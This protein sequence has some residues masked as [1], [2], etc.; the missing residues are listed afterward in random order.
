MITLNEEAKPESKAS[1]NTCAFI[2]QNYL[3]TQHVLYITIPRVE[4]KEGEKHTFTFTLENKNGQLLE[5]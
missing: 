4:L 5:A 1:T 3:G 2:T